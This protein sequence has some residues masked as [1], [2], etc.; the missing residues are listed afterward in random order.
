MSDINSKNSIKPNKKHK[1]KMKKLILILALIIAAPL[2]SIQAQSNIVIINLQ[3]VFNE[4]HKTQE[5]QGL[6]NERLNQ[7]QKEMQ[8]MQTDFQKLVDETQK[9]RDQVMDQAL[10]PAAKA[11]RQK[12]FE[13]KIKQVQ[14][15]ERKVQEFRSSRARQFEEQSARMR[16]GIIE[17]ITKVVEKFGKD[18]K[19]N[20]ILDVS[21][22]SMAATSVVLYAD[23]YRDITEDILKILNSNRPASPPKP[24]AR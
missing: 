24:A 15:M 23:G 2:A 22:K 14:D 17:E 4:Y 16:Q 12:A 21:G 7:F 5:T 6:L 18:N 10:S 8:E 9:L 13:A 11:E 3:K 19:F 1:P 20:L